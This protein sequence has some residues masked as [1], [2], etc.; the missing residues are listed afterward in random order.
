MKEHM[1]RMQDN[2]TLRSFRLPPVRALCCQ[3]IF[4]AHRS[5]SSLFCAF[6]SPVQTL[7]GLEEAQR[8]RADVLKQLD[9]EREEIRVEKRNLA[10]R[11]AALDS[12]EAALRSDEAE[13]QKHVAYF[14][15]RM[16]ELTALG[17]KV[18]AQS[19]SVA[20]Q[21][22][23]LASERAL[24][25]QAK[26]EARS[27]IDEQAKLKEAGEAELA[28][29]REQKVLH[30][31]ERSSLLA[32]QKKFMLDRDLA[33]RALQV[34]KAIQ[35]FHP[36]HAPMGSGTPN[37]PPHILSPPLPPSSATAG[38][39][40]ASFTHEEP[41]LLSHSFRT[42]DPGAAAILAP[43]TT[44]HALARSD[45]H[46]ALHNHAYDSGHI[47]AALASLSSHADHLRGFMQDEKILSPRATV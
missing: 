30:E 45:R 9:D 34:S 14:E 2:R 7:E 39:L 43:Q 36:S 18:K 3:L 25:E 24:V 21:Y 31:K 37:Y 41:S 47:S 29:L 19:E 26:L 6:V 20:E 12:N 42:A 4:I 27:Y 5:L 38:G 1:V 33:M 46:A 32:D 28:R 10:Q 35:G 11:R 16:S 23:R 40:G 17:A 15:S 22:G 44:P 13:F 8:E